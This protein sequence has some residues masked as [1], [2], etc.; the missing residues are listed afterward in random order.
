MTASI[1]SPRAAT[2]PECHA[3]IARAGIARATDSDGIITI[4]Q[5]TRLYCTNDRS[6]PLEESSLAVEF[7]AA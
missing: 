4:E 2:C 1:G 7:S 3:V 6:H 5:G